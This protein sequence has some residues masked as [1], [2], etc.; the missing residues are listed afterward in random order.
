VPVNHL[1][2]DPQTG[3]PRIMSVEH[4]VDDDDLFLAV[5]PNFLELKR[6]S[7]ALA[8]EWRLLTRGLFLEYLRRGYVVVDFITAG[9][10][11]GY[12]LRRPAW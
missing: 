9:A 2:A 10:W 1:I 5:P 6:L 7:L 11:P 3:L 4:D 12:V 8:Q